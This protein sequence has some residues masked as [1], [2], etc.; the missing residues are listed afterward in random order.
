MQNTTRPRPSVK[1]KCRNAPERGN[2]DLSVP[3]MD[4]DHFKDFNDT[5]GHQE[6]DLVLTALGRVVTGEHREEDSACR[7]GGEEFVRDRA[8]REYLIRH[9][10]NGPTREPSG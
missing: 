2:T 4:V 9:P 5:Y 7:C 6:G 3:M 8:L 1:T 10:T